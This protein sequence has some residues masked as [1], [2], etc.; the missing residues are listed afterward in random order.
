MRR[1]LAR[2]TWLRG[3]KFPS[4]DYRFFASVDAKLSLEDAMDVVAVEDPAMARMS[5]RNGTDFVLL[6]DDFGV[7]CFDRVID[8]LRVRPL[9]RFA[10]TTGCDSTRFSV[11]SSDVAAAMAHSQRDLASLKLTIFDDSPRSVETTAASSQ[12]EFCETHIHAVDASSMTT[13]ADQTAKTSAENKK[14]AIPIIHQSSQ[15]QCLFRAED[16]E[17][18]DFWAAIDAEK[19]AEDCC[20]PSSEK[21]EAAAHTCSAYRARSMLPARRSATPR[22]AILASFPGS[23]NTWSRMLVEYATG[24]LTGSI[25]DD[26]ELKRSLPA[27][28]NRN[29]S[30]VLL[31]KA[32]V[33]PK[34]YLTMVTANKIVLVSRHP[35][36]A[37][38]AE[39]Q[40]RIGIY[41]TTQN[42]HVHVVQRFGPALNKVFAR[43]ALC[44]SCKW[45]LYALA[46]AKVDLPV[47]RVRYENLVKSDDELRKILD[48][49][50]FE[51][52]ERRVKCSRQLAFDP[53]IRR[54]KSNMT[55]VS[56]F[57]V[58]FFTLFMQAAVFGSD[59][60][61][62]CEAWHRITANPASRESKTLL[63]QY[64]LSRGASS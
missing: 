22:G 21:V 40:R 28:G 61:M 62:A 58:S 7:V 2:E 45:A 33:M 32:H 30:Q 57:H 10:W 64:V 25:Y 41:G 48:F 34:Q 15:Q 16:E 50:G 9:Q 17:D 26:D 1:R 55:A 6:A 38:W 31:V 12:T 44:M 19:Q 59:K 4:C 37:T 54:A 52:S 23:G 63:S 27:E 8:E 35:F 39:F 11:L 43:F 29:T 53:S 20:A 36:S 18:H 56:L 42:S 14:R 24:V 13:R 49:L 60:K 51:T 46:H 3:C 47:H 5:S